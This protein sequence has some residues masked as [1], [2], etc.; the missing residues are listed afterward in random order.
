M[1]HQDA[2]SLVVAAA[3]VIDDTGQS[4]IFR[5]RQNIWCI[6]QRL[7]D[8]RNSVNSIFRLQHIRNV[9]TSCVTVSSQVNDERPFN[10]FNL[11]VIFVALFPHS[12]RTLRGTEN[13]KKNKSECEN[14]PVECHI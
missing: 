3:A 10:W 1:N 5:R 8:S 4:S 2:K 12:L 11:S 7:S 13:A 14:F 9:R 6:S